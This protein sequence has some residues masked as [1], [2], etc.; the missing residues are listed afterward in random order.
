MPLGKAITMGS[1]QVADK[2]DEEVGKNVVN[3]KMT[4]EQMKA[5]M[6]DLAESLNGQMGELK[7]QIM[8]LLAK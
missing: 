1:A 8:L 3:M 7:E 2:E 4:V 6:E 5:D